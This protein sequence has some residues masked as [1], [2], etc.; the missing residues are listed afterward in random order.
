MVLTENGIVNGGLPLILILISSFI[1]SSLLASA[2]TTFLQILHNSII[3]NFYY[4]FIKIFINLLLQ[5]IFLI[6]QDLVYLFQDKL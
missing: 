4:S 2:N 5:L 6:N 1:I 3:F